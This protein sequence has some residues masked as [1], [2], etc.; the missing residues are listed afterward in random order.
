[1]NTPTET[2][3]PSEVSAGFSKWLAAQLKNKRMTQRQLALFSGVDH[4]TISRLV[5]GGRIPSFETATKIAN[6]LREPLMGT[7]VTAQTPM[8]RVEQSLRSDSLL[9]ES[10]VRALMSQYLKIRNNNS[11]AIAAMRSNRPVT[12]MNITVT[13]H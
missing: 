5:R 12:E 10:Q 6:G 8:A 13:R 11:T 7:A 9:S 3:I 2:N 1:M 4:S